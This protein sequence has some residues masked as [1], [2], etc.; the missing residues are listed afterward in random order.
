MIVL[1]KI[2]GTAILHKASVLYTIASWISFGSLRVSAQSRKC[3]VYSC[4]ERLLLIPFDGIF[5]EM[6]FRVRAELLLQN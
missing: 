2:S 4:S 6:T 1:H 3:S 5:S